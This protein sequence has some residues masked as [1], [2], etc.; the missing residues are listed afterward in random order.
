MLPLVI[1]RFIAVCTLALR[2]Y[3]FLAE[4]VV[5]IMKAISP[6]ISFDK[7][8][9]DKKLPIQRVC[10]FSFSIDINTIETSRKYI[11]LKL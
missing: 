3:V 4:L 7:F 5:L 9:F 1:L 8:V 10:I 2:V 6:V 11:E